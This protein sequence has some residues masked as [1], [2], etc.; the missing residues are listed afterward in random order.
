[1]PNV[2]IVLSCSGGGC[3]CT[4]GRWGWLPSVLSNTLC[5]Q[6]P[7]STGSVCLCGWQACQG[8]VLV[9]LYSWGL[10]VLYFVPPSGIVKEIEPMPFVFVVGVHAVGSFGLTWPPIVL[11]YL[12]A[13]VLAA[14]ASDILTATS[15]PFGSSTEIVEDAELALVRNHYHLLTASACGVWSSGAAVLLHVHPSFGYA[16]L[17]A[18]RQ[19]LLPAFHT[20]VVRFVSFEELSR[21]S[22]VLRLYRRQV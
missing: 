21:L 20:F 12:L 22:V 14:A 6:C 2:D 11:A 18:F 13:H 9:F 4:W 15:Y 19:G 16:P 5:P 1:M 3:R 7:H 17:C 10:Y 8:Y